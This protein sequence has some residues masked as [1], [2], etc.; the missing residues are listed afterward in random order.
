MTDD[1]DFEAQ[2]LEGILEGTVDALKSMM[3]A[4]SIDQNI[5]ISEARSS[6]SG[7]NFRLYNVFVDGSIV[8]SIRTQQLPAEKVLIDF[9]AVLLESKPDERF[10]IVRDALIERLTRVGFKP[11]KPQP[12]RGPIG[13]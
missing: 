8:G 12:K 11:D 9:K 10:Y 6:L 13:F 3:V 4:W 5:R 7:S 1:V 2:T